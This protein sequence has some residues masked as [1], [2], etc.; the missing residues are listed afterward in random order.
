MNL[1]LAL[2]R[3][4]TGLLEP[5]VPSLLTGR[6][7]RGKEDV[8]RIGERLAKRRARARMG[9]WFGCMG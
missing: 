1:P 9:T 2:Y 8:A 6:A 4:V 3:G 5:W 7:K